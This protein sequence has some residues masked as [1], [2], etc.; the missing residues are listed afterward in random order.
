LLR[1]IQRDFGK[2]LDEDFERRLVDC[3]NRMTKLEYFKVETV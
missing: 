3:K 2:R 1:D